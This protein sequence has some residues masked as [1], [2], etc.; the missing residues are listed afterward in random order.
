MNSTTGR[1]VPSR[2]GAWMSSLWRAAGPKAMSRASAGVPN[3]WAAASAGSER[4]QGS[5]C[6]N[7]AQCVTAIGIHDGLCGTGFE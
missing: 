7:E 3:S 6:R 2:G 1:R 5:A 4:R